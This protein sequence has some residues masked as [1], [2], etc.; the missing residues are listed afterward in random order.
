M[1]PCA[2]DLKCRLACVQDE[3]FILHDVAQRTWGCLFVCW[4]GN[5]IMQLYYTTVIQ[6]F[7]PEDKYVCTL[8]ATCNFLNPNFRCFIITSF[9]IFFLWSRK[10]GWWWSSKN[11][12]TFQ[13]EMYVKNCYRTKK[14]K[15]GSSARQIMQNSIKSS[16]SVSVQ[17][18]ISCLCKF[19]PKWL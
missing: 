4:E 2:H 7:D 11:K 5:F 16:I 15:R 3:C 10:N 18:K 19:T 8:R 13:G 17:A 9:C 6:H 12:I 14:T 1:T